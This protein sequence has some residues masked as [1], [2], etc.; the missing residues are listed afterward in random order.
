MLMCIHLLA[1][2]CFVFFS[3]YKNKMHKNLFPVILFLVPALLQAQNSIRKIN[4]GKA[5]SPRITTVFHKLGD[6]FVR[7]RTYQYGETKEPFF[8]SLHADEVTAIESTTKLLEKTGG[9]LVKIENNKTRNIR[10]RMNGK[11]YTC[12]PNRIFSRIGIIQTLSMFGKVDDKAINEVDKF[13]KRLLQML[14]DSSSC[15]ISLHNNSNGKFSVTSYLPGNDRAKDATAVHSVKNQDPDD[16]FFTTD[17]I[18]YKSLAGEN[19]NTILQD[20]ENAKKDGSLSI[21][22]GEKNIRYLNCETEHGRSNQYYQMIAI[23]MG[24]VLQTEKQELNA[25]IPEKEQFKKPATTIAYN[26]RLLSDTLLNALSKGDKIYFGNREV[27]QITKINNNQPTGQMEMT[28]D[29]PLYD[30]MDFYVISSSAGSNKPKI[31]LR[32]DPT[33]PKE[34][35]DAETATIVMKV[36]P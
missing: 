34:P 9:T 36:M 32:I 4:T 19:Y 10:F 26:Y 1:H 28:K 15:I 17:S 24:H 31:E 16:I 30:N 8:I 14:P 12:D 29:F 7:V 20:N 6:D 11:Y 5:F 33:R 27:G 3:L 21:Y 13:A 18:L 23:A 2:K 35:Y 25:K 22:C